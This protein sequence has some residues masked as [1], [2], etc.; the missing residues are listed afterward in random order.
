[1]IIAIS[2][3]Q[4][5]AERIMTADPVECC[6]CHAMHFFFVNR[7]GKTR[8]FVCD[9]QPSAPLMTRQQLV[10][11]ARTDY[12]TFLET[13]KAERGPWVCSPPPFSLA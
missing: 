9:L 4:D 3:G 7:L 10:A 6:L 2:H 1:M 13:A 11:Q 8:C 5:G 12:R